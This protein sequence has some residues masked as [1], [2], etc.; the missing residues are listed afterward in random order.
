M[1][2]DENDE[3]LE[4]KVVPGARDYP[5]YMAVM[6]GEPLG[7]SSHPIA[8]AYNYFRHQIEAGLRLDAPTREELEPEDVTEFVD[9]VTTGALGDRGGEDASQSQAELE[10]FEEAEVEE[11]AT[12]VSEEPFN[13]QGLLNAVTLKLELVTISDVT[14]ENAYN[15]FRTLNSTGLSLDQVDLLRNAF[16]MLLPHRATEVHS[17]L[18]DPMETRLGLTEL[19]RFFHTN[20]IR[21]GENIPYLQ[22]Y[23]TQLQRLK[24]AGLGQEAIIGQ[25]ETIEKDS[26]LYSTASLAGPGP[27]YV[28]GTRLDD[29]TVNALQLLRAWG[30]YPALPL[31]LES[32]AQLR[33][34]S[35]SPADFGR[36][37]SWIES[38]LVRRFILGIPP[39]DLRSTF[40][41][42]MKSLAESG[43]SFLSVLSTELRKP[44]VRWPS[45]AE[46]ER[47]AEQVD[48]YRGRQREEFYILRRLAEKIEGREYPHISLGTRAGQ[49]SIE[50]VLPQ[51]EL[52]QAW[53]EELQS[54]GDADAFK[55]W[56]ERKDVLGNLTLTAY[57]SSLSNNPFIEKKAFMRE[58]SRLELS[59]H[60]LDSAHWTRVQIDQ[61]SRYL[62]LQA[63]AVWPRPE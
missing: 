28:G 37:L 33:D 23:R 10:E 2:M 61:R 60:I 27:Y 59:R 40:G 52:T 19:G 57:N 50:H 41:R 22:T 31:I 56:R 32:A 12:A 30:S 55:S 47:A 36:V 29:R 17:R 63:T 14:P 5:P 35:I 4:P 38:I 48:F 39:N 6:K 24:R 21:L 42:V 3:L 34:G 13:W 45:N 44:Y 49:F 58:N 9:G 46:I 53:A 25:L 26:Q 18:W 62:A 51:G 16:F 43:G 20:L 11:A 7:R 8:L 15:V 54:E 1:H